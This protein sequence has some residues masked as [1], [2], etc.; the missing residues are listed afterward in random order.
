MH[1]QILVYP[2]GVERRC[3]KARQEHVD[4]DKQI[5][6]TLFHFVR[7]VFVIVLEALAGC[8]KVGLE[9]LVVLVNRH[10]QKITGVLVKTISIEA[11]IVQYAVCTVCF[12]RSKREDGGN[13]QITVLFCNLFFQFQ[14]VFF[15][16]RDGADSKHGVET[17]HM[18]TLQT[19]IGISH[20]LLVE[21]FQNV[22]HNFGDT[23]LR[24]KCFLGINGSNLLVLLSVLLLY[25]VDIVNAE[26]QNISV[27]DSVNDGVCVEFIAKCLLGGFE[28][29]I[30]ASTCID[31]E[32]RSARKTKDMI[33]S[34]VSVY[35]N[36]LF[37]L[38][39]LTADNSRMHITELASM[40]FIEYQN[41]MLIPDGV[42]GVLL[43]KDIQFLNRSYDNSRSRILK[44]LLKDSRALVAVSSAL[45][46]SVILF[47]GLIVQVL[48]VNNKQHL[49]NVW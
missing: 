18:L 25:R 19:V 47:D 43:N 3:I 21:V 42:H 28:I 16:S 46:K 4:H 38:F 12:V 27:I 30:S 6:F 31:R 37:T 8:V 7:E 48:T 49:V 11:F 10:I 35:F 23:L 1:F 29:R 32:N 33:V 24:S 2:K 5:N 22:L 20:S 9:S 13:R 17:I 44:L 26:R 45:F 40:A 41:N 39:D 15:A 34:K 14:I 36:N